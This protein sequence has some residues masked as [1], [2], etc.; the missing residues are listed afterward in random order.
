MTNSI[1]PTSTPTHNAAPGPYGYALLGVLPKLLQNPLQFLLTTA[2]QYGDVVY[3]GLGALQTYLVT[4][5]NHVKYVL[6]DNNSNYC[7]PWF[8]K[9]EHGNGVLTSEGS[10]W[11]RQR[12]LVQQAFHH[13]RISALVPIITN[14]AEAMLERWRSAA[15][16]G[17]TLDIAA[18]MRRLSW[19]VIVKTMFGLDVSSKDNTAERVLADRIWRKVRRSHVDR[20]LWTYFMPERLLVSRQVNTAEADL[21]RLIYERRS[22]GEDTGDLLSMLL[23]AHDERTG[24]GMSDTQVYDEVM[25]LFTAGHETTANT[26]T[27]IWYLL[28]MHPGIERQLHMELAV[29]LGGHAP[30]FEDL[31]TLT[32]TKMVID[33]AMRLYPPIWMFPRTPVKDD[34]IGGYRIPAN[35]IVMLSPYVTHHHPAFWS[36]PEGFD[37]ERFAPELATDRPRFAYFPFGGGPRLCIGNSFGLMEMQVVLALVAQTYHLDLVP[38]HPIEPQARVTLRPRHGIP[39]TLRS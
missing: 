15:D 25:A 32:Y 37:P 23:L 20:Q 7:K 38:G 24:E 10:F 13:Q 22:S 11:L 33:E 12:R 35:S 17:T 31:H 30:N 29:V 4:H 36:N 16:R 26:L 6:Q 5:P 21:Y 39:M 18:E 34:E 27:W 9:Q 19:E 8:V 3:L 1:L 2:D 14:V 28:S